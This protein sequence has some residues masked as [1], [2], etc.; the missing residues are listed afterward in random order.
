MSVGIWTFSFDAAPIGQVREAA[1]EI[2]ELG[3]DSL[4]FGEYPGREALTQ[5]ALLLGATSRITVATGVARFD[6]RSPAGVAGG[7]RTLAEAHPGRFTLGL[8]GHARG[9]RPVESIRA[10]LDE[11]DAAEFTSPEPVPPP[12]K[13]LAA[14]GP[15]MLR[16]AAERTD[17]AHPYFVP[18]EHTALAREIMGPDAYLAVEQGVVL[19]RA[20]GLDIARA[21]VGFYLERTEHHR[22]NLKR[23][24]FTDDDLAGSDRLVE[25]VIAVG[26]EA[27]AGRVKAHL[28]AGA[29]HVCVQ[30][31]TGEPGLPLDG[32]RRLAELVL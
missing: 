5:A 8:G 17:G 10:Y 11:M 22:V 28:D 26:E 30:V 3:F 20:R 1:A 15:R 13:L 25:S 29:D 32:W 7:A 31:I 18:P 23:L 19:D 12:R 21:E 14:L 16:L 4:W 27:I 6:R 9:A 24:G 2:E